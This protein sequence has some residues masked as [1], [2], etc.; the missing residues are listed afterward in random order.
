MQCSDISITNPSLIALSIR[1]YLGQPLFGAHYN[2]Q[3]AHYQAVFTLS[4]LLQ[5]SLWSHISENKRCPEDNKL[6]P[7]DCR[8][9]G[10][11]P[12]LQRDQE[13]QQRRVPVRLLRLIRLQEWDQAREQSVPPGEKIL[14]LNTNT[15]QSS[16]API[17]ITASIL[18]TNKTRCSFIFPSIIHLLVAKR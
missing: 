6:V 13:G 12:L 1:H 2:W 15:S 8:P 16:G 10:L 5:N 18:K 4:T 3:S 9:R 7:D 17:I 11:P 14:M